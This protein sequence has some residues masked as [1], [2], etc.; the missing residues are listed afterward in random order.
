VLGFFKSADIDLQKGLLLGGQYLSV[1]AYTAVE[2]SL[3]YT[4]QVALNNNLPVFNISECIY[5]LK[6]RNNLKSEELLILQ[7]NKANAIF[8]TSNEFDSK[9]SVSISIFDYRTRQAL[10]TTVCK[11][12]HSVVKIPI[13]ESNELGKDMYF[14]RKSLYG[15]DIFNPKDKAFNSRCLSNVDT[16]TDWDTNLN[17]RRFNYFS[18]KAAVCWPSDCTYQGISTNAYM[19]CR[20][21]GLNSDSYYSNTFSTGVTLSTMTDINVAVVTCHKAAFSV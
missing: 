20:C 15:I 6:A 14:S 17:Y 4:H 19:E 7:S 1:L 16:S 21:E 12:G 9:Y 2:Q 13:T 10:D 18:G 8:S 3:N 11:N 5:I